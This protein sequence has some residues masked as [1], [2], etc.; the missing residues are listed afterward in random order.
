MYM[1]QNYVPIIIKL[2]FLVAG[3]KTKGS[4]FGC[5]D[6]VEQFLCMMNAICIIMHALWI[7]ASWVGSV[8]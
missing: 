1:E 8:P 7:T 4:M 6:T 3:I 2:L 5:N